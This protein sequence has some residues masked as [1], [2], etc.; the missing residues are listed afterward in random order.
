MLNTVCIPHVSNL[1]SLARVFKLFRLFCNPLL[2]TT[3]TDTHF[4]TIVVLG[5]TMR[6]LFYKIYLII[7]MRPQT[8]DILIT[9]Y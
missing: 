7:F 6:F 8:T 4:A 3:P 5:G 1:I 2:A 9:V